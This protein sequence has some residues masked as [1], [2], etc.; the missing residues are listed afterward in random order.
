VDRQRSKAALKQAL[1]LSSQVTDA[2]LRAHTRAYWGHWYARFRS[3][4][5]EDAAACTTVIAAARQAGARGL[6]SMHVARSCYFQYVQSDYWAVCR[7]A[8]EGLPLALEAGHHF[9][10][11][12]CQYYRALALL[13][14]GQWGDMLHT[15]RD[16]FHMAEDNGHHLARQLLQLVMA[17]LHEHAGDFASA[18]IL[19]EQVL[20]QAQETRHA[21]GYFLSLILLGSAHQGLGHA[22]RAWEC[23]NAILQR[24]EDEPD[25][26]EWIFQMPLRCSLSA[27]WLAQGAFEPARQEAKRLCELAAQPGERTYL[28]LGKIALAEQQW[29]PAEAEL[30]QALAV[31]EGAEAPLAAWRVY[32]TA[33]QLSVQR[34]R[35]TEAQQYWARSAAVLTQLADSLGNAL[36]LRQSL[37]TSL[38]GAYAAG[39]THTIEERKNK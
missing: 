32:A 35:R 18:R 4:R 1:A 22:E 17:W 12:Y 24:L 10:Y 13:H 6:L 36:E 3:W 20:A 34:G 21:T 39:E 31:L 33:A 37:L 23:F 7:T 9:D 15:L 5:E 8:A 27:Y 19:C 38:P 29:E 2:L 25:T 26:M 28:A 16:G 14:L 11:L 30:S